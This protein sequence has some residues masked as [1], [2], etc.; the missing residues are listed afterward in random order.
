MKSFEEF[1]SEE[2]NQH[3]A[4][5]LKFNKATAAHRVG[6]DDYHHNAALYHHH[7]SKAETSAGNHAG[8]NDHR[9]QVMIHSSK[10]M[11]QGARDR[12]HGHLDK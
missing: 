2:Y 7:M 9:N 3:R 8:S 4:T 11:D 1:L 10:V 5:A 6:T 12:L